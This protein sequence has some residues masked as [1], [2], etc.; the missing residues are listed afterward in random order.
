MMSLAAGTSSF[1]LDH[2]FIAVSRRA[3]EAR[4]LRRFGLIEGS[5]NRHPGQGT[6]N[7]RFFFR[8]A[9][10][11]LLWLENPVEA[12]SE[13]IR[14]T[15]L[16][17]RLRALSPAVSP[18]GVCLR[19][20]GPADAPPFPGWSY[21]PPYLPPHLSIDVAAEAPPAEPM[22][23]SLA[24][25]RRPDA[26]AAGRGE[27][28]FHPRGLREITA[29]DITRPSFQPLSAAARCLTE[30]GLVR[31]RFGPDHLLELSFDDRGAG[32]RVDFRPDL[33]LVFH[34]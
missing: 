9:M 4:H 21:R 17:E 28:L 3:P 24:F 29:V 13:A 5:P 31:F 6:A 1:E 15:G 12:G 16:R 8:N 26:P 14:R 22:W 7:R 19:P 34:W 23:F 30:L 18:F 20:R 2:L 11:E 10:L 25:G 27:P 33:P 32:R